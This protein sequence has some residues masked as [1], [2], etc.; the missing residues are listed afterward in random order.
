MNESV[1]RQRAELHR[2]ADP[3]LI[4]AEVIRLHREGLR[5][6]DIAQCLSLNDIDVLA[7][8]ARAIL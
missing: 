6:R 8:I 2:P 4:E 3:K 5:P 7:I 1:Y